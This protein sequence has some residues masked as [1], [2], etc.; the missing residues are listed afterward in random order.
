VKTGK[1]GAIDLGSG[2]IKLSVFENLDGTWKALAL[3]EQNTELRRGMGSGC[4]LQAGPVAETLKA[5]EDFVRR[6]EDL[7]CSK[8]PAYGTSALRKATNRELLF[9]PLKQRFGIEPV[10]LTEEEEGRLNLLGALARNSEGERAQLVMDPGGDSSECCWGENWKSAEV[11]SLPFG[12]VS[13]QER[14]GNE[15]PGGPIPAA[16]LESLRQWVQSSLEAFAPAKALKKSRLS[17][18]IR[19]NEP[20]ARA[21]AAFAGRPKSSYELDDLRALTFGM[22]AMPHEAR[23]QLIAGE[24][25]GKVDRTPFGF[26][27][28]IALLEWMDAGVF[29]VEPWG[30]K[31]GAALFL[32]GM[33]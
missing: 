32:N 31:L 1:V 16:A 3:E 24:P 14:F 28:W 29:S 33:A 20:V 7:G 8:A 17:P 9:E 5:V 18:A 6:T 21:L 27:S 19:M 25:V 30:I 13:L 2:T 12:S 15:G 26:M 10:I 11:A 22:A 23:V 4:L